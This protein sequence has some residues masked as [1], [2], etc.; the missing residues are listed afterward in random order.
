VADYAE[1]LPRQA[2]WLAQNER[3]S[4]GSVHEAS[5]YANECRLAGAVWSK[6]QQSLAGCQLEIEIK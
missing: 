3:I 6:Q 5:E 1:L 4:S 2:W